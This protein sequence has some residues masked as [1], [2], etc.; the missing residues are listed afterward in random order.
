MGTAAAMKPLPAPDAEGEKGKEEEGKGKAKPVARCDAYLPV[1][2]LLHVR[3]WPS[4]CGG[5]KPSR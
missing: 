4:V 1:C 2:A 3:Y 5:Q